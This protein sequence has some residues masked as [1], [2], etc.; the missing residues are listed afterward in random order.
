MTP[1]TMYS[2]SE[3]EMNELVPRKRT[4]IPPPPGV[5]E[6]CVICAPAILP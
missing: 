4:L 5:P 1:S 3:P 2:G 6:F